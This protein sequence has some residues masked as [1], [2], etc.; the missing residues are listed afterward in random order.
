MVPIPSSWSLVGNE[1]DHYLQFTANNYSSVWGVSRSY[2]LKPSGQSRN[3]GGLQ[4]SRHSCI[5]QSNL[6]LSVAL[7]DVKWHRGLFGTF[8][9]WYLFNS[10]LKW[11]LCYIVTISSSQWKS[12][13]H[14]SSVDP[15]GENMVSWQVMET[16]FDLILFYNSLEGWRHFRDTIGALR[17]VIS[18]NNYSRLTSEICLE[19]IPECHRVHCKD[20]SIGS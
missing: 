6:Y 15:R 17:L 3:D 11:W 4:G 13:S 19:W 2:N 12:I 18:K 7:P 14:Y 1:P 10:T 5:R 20:V 8:D 9:C 16:E